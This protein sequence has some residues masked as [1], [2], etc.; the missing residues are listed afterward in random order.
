MCVYVNER[1]CNASN[2]IVRKQVCTRDVEMLSLSFRPKYLPR[3]FGQVFVTT[4]YIQP[5][6]NV[7][8]A[9]SEVAD[10]VGLLSLRFKIL[11]P[12]APNFVLGDMNSCDLQ[13]S[14]SPFSNS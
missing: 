8:R 4:V 12:D 9:A 14:L 2:I 5:D 7:K 1:W 10:V 13:P 3:E 11:S 6:D